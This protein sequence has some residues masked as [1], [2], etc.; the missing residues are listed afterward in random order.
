MPIPTRAVTLT[1]IL[2]LHMVACSSTSPYQ[3]LEP[4]DL[5]AMASM[6]YDEGEYDNAIEALERLLASFGNW[7]RLPEAR[8]LLGHARFA[9]ED[10]LTARTE[11]GRFLDRYPSHEGAPAASL[12]VCRS[13]AELSPHPQRDQGFTQDAWTACRNVVL[14]HRGSPE[15]AEGA[16][17]ANRMRLKL[18]E[19]EF[20]R[21]EFYFRRKLYDSAIVYYEFV[22]NLYSETEFAPR[23]LLGLYRSNLAIGYEDLAEE[24]KARLLAEYPDSEAAQEIRTNGNS[25]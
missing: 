21:G 23:A 16:E 20:G 9:K 13:L 25:G 14:D 11:Y 10:Y 22:V 2:S 5:F 19:S 8:L 7:P 18:A 17:I 24:A 6:E 1:A 12:G 3:G 4:E 15:A